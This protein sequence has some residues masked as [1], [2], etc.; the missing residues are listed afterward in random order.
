MIIFTAEILK[1]GEWGEKT[2]WTYILIPQ[3][4]AEKINPGCRKS[5]RVKGKLDGHSIHQTAL[6]PMGAGDFILPLNAALRKAIRKR[7]G[8]R[9][10]VQLTMDKKPLELSAALLECLNDEPAAKEF[11][12]SLAPSHRQYYSK[13]IESA[14]TDATKSK[15]IGQAINAFVLKMHYSDMMRMLKEQ[16]R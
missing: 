7:K 2:G 5:Y 13:W 10:E 6:I 14:K 16:G 3:K 15:R 4:M 12:M 8:D 1:F 9:L 11:F